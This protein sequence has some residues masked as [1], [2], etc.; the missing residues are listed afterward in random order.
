MSDS[1]NTLGS[2]LEE[3]MRHVTALAPEGVDVLMTILRTLCVIGGCKD[4][5]PFPQG[6]VPSAS[7][8]ASGA[9][10]SASPMD[11]DQNPT[12]ESL[13]SHIQ[14]DLGGRTARKL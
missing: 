13:L 11:T 3:L 9:A 12:Y 14:A 8:D 2:N 10:A 6:S 7:E 5:V 4:P 1:P